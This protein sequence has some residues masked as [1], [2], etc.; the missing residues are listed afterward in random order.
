MPCSAD[1]MAAKLSPGTVVAGFRVESSV[2]RGAMA[3]VY[4]AC[5]EDGHVVALKLL[6]D[7]LAHDERFR[8]RFLRESQIAAGLHHPNIVP[9]LSSGEDDGRLYLAMQYIDGEDLRDLLRREGRL[10]PERAIDLVAQ[11]AAALDTAHHAGLVHRDVKPGNI[12]LSADGETAFICDFGLARHVASVSSLTGDRGFVGTIDYV[13][14]EQIEGGTDRRARRRILA[15]LRPLRMPRRCTPLRPRLRAVRRL[16]PPQRTPT[17]AHRPTPR[18]APSLRRPLRHRPRQEPRRPLPDLRRT[19]SRSTSSTRRPNP[20]PQQTPPPA[21]TCSHPHRHSSDR[22]R[23]AVGAFL[24]TRSND[25]P[26]TITPTSIAGAKLGDSNVLLS[27]MWGGGQRLVMTEPPNYSVLTQH[28]RNLSAYFIGTGDKTV[29]I[30]TW[31][32]ADRTAE[33]IGPCSTVAELKKAYGPRLKPS[34]YNTHNGIVFAWTVGK[35]LA[36]TTEP[37]PE[38]RH[39]TIVRSVGLYSNPLSWA[40]FNASNDGPCARATNTSVVQ[41]PARIPVVVSPALPTMLASRSFKPRVSVRV[42]KGWA[43]GHDT[44]HSFSVTSPNG[45]SIE[46]VLDPLAST[47]TGGPLRTIS[48]TPRG[49]TT[50]LQ[51]HP[52]LALTAPQTV[53]MGTPLLTATSLDV[54]LSKAGPAGGVTYFITPGG[55]A[56]Q[57]PRPTC[58]PLPHAGSDRHAGAHASPSSSSRP[59]RRHSERRCRRRQR[60]SRT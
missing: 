11:I 40:S 16:R 23:R 13:P 18:P 4:R 27:R 21:A 17:Q 58:A 39:P 28:T 22:R 3:E 31:N 48:T 33:G 56:S 45:S 35:H 24:L 51:K 50:W 54:R 10:D 5:G 32:A 12:L 14:P 52:G 25:K 36:F 29:E 37:V 42:P 15:R 8:R 20:R 30:T 53:L 9:T 2:G 6:D 34:P 38:G 41:R 1:V 57:H 60:S 44:P 47:P 43:L 7:S 49:L 55:D 26:A 19:R 59:R 46:F